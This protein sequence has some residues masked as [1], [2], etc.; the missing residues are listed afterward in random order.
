M[1]KTDCTNVERSRSRLLVFA[2]GTL[3]VALGDAL[4]GIGFYARD[5]A[6]PGV[7]ATS[8]VLGL[9]AGALY[10]WGGL[11]FGRLVARP[12]L[13][14]VTEFA[15]LAFG[16]TLAVVHAFAAAIMHVENQRLVG[17]DLPVLELLVVELEQT[18]A[19]LAMPMFVALTVG[20]GA[21]AWATIRRAMP[22]PPWTV[23]L[24]ALVLCVPQQ[25][26]ADALW[27][28][29][30]SPALMGTVHALSLWALLARLP[31]SLPE[32]TGDGAQK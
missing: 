12:G 4:Y 19:I 7:Y 26:M 6:N 2:I 3:L 13:R 18:Y 20:Y 21:F 23:A 9:I 24:N 8:A 25:W 28:P 15:F 11:G 31:A 30:R 32:A 29:L 14:R 22:L 27:F 1:P 16:F 5:V 17:G 10:M